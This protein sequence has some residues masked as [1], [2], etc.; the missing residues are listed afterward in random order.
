MP[1]LELDYILLEGNKKPSKAWSE[2]QVKCFLMEKSRHFIC[3]FSFT[4]YDLGKWYNSK[5]IK[6]EKR[7]RPII[8]ASAYEMSYIFLIR[9][10]IHFNVM[11]PSLVDFVSPSLY[12]NF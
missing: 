7:Y 9:I 1:S 8:V 5:A 4:H 11:V 10:A 6:Y 3:C 2:C 12:N